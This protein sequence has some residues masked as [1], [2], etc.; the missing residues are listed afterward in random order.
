MDKH[1]T[2]L[3]IAQEC[4][5]L[6]QQE[7]IDDYQIAKQKA[8]ARLG[9]PYK[10]LPSNQEIEQALHQYQQL[11]HADTQAER[12]QK[13]RHTALSAM[14][15]LRDFQP[16]LVGKLVKGTSHE[17]SDVT[18]HVFSD[19]FEEIGWFLLERKIPYE[20]GE[21]Y[22]A[23]RSECYPCYRFMAGD[24]AISLTVFPLDKMR[25]A[26]PDPATGKPMRRLDE[27]GVRAL[28]AFPKDGSSCL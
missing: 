6:M 25:Q 22:Y 4:A 20:L 24:D 21:R 17:Y 27:N 16:R 23:N 8:T 13:K 7:C 1:L 14:Q 3:R 10:Y 11:F 15:L 9:L 28:L 18:L 26:P 12:L 19:T 5:R 2:R